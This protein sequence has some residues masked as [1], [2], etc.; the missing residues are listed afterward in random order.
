[1]I[2]ATRATPAVTS[3]AS[4]MPSPK[5]TATA[6]VTDRPGS[7]GSE[8]IA[9]RNDDERAADQAAA[10]DQRPDVRG[11]RGHDRECGERGDAEAE[12]PA[13]AEDV[14]ELAGRRPDQAGRRADAG[15]RQPA[16]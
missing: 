11:E 6:A 10:G 4:A 9:S 15:R 1:M 2:K 8:A 12:Y 14:A 7:G 5:P 3:S 13:P 16:S